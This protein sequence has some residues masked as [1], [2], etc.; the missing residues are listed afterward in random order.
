MATELGILSYSANTLSYHPSATVDE[1]L[2]HVADNA[3]SFIT[4]TGFGEDRSAVKVLLAHFGLPMTLAEDIIDDTSVEFVG[5]AE[6]FL[7]LEHAVPV[8]L[9]GQSVPEPARISFILGGT[10][11]LLFEKAAA[12]I[13]SKTL[14]RIISGQSKAQRYGSDYLLYLLLRASVLEH[15]QVTFLHFNTRLDNLEDMVLANP[16]EEGA[17]REIL[18][19]REEL[20]PWNIPLLELE[21][22][23]EFVTDAESDFITPATSRYYTKSLYREVGDLLDAYLRL[24]QWLKEIMDLHMAAVNRRANKVM[25]LLTVVATIFLPLTFITSLYGMN[26]ANMPELDEPWAYP[27]VLAVLL[28]IALGSL[29]YMKR[30]DWI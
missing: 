10:Y 8:L 2:G 29:Y 1:L 16:A 9:P 5:E 30:R 14:H 23:L 28:L 11:L 4:C 7:Y 22:F 6:H 13:F 21:D 15:Y 24:R 3:N 27:A 19:A 26:F 25:Q 17:Y 20:K 12:P 18:V